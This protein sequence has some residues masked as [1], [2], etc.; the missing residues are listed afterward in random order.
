MLRLLNCLRTVG[1]LAYT[2]TSP[3]VADSVL[4]QSRFAVSAT[5][6]QVP[7]SDGTFRY[8][9][10]TY[11]VPFISPEAQ[12]TSLLGPDGTVGEPYVPRGRSIGLENATL[13]E[14]QSAFTGTWTLAETRGAEE[15]QYQF[16]IP[17]L[18]LDS[19]SETPIVV[20]P[21]E[22]ATVYS[23]FELQYGYASG[24]PPQ[25]SN[26]RSAGDGGLREFDR[27]R[28]SPTSFRYEFEL[29]DGVEESTLSLEFG[30]QE[31]FFFNVTPKSPSAD[32]VFSF[33]S[34]IL[35]SWSKPLT[36]TAR[37]PEPYSG[38]L[39]APA[40]IGFVGRRER[41]C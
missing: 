13:S 40:L 39:I 37:V 24:N 8:S 32:A 7:A 22:G 17:E 27:E 18:N 16:E 34:V 9:F 1:I 23:G 33:E 4:A 29:K 10:F 28:V 36:L 35:K 14:L 5:V 2:C 30:S 20:S 31:F 25:V 12:V 41:K 15:L 11:A 6:D 21:S 3:F 26:F 38:L 19:F